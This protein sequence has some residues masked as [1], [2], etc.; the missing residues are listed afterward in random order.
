MGPMRQGAGVKSGR[1]A[2]LRLQER[3]AVSV[4]AALPAVERVLPP[5]AAVPRQAGRPASAGWTVPSVEGCHLRGF[6]RLL[7]ECVRVTGGWR[8]VMVIQHHLIYH[9][10]QNDQIKK[11]HF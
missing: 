8:V 7:R 5:Q 9:D 4:F 3:E 10:Y 1:V 11:S 6:L 2:D